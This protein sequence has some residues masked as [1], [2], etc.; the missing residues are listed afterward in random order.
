MTQI[1]VYSFS[2]FNRYMLNVG[3]LA[4]TV[5]GIRNRELNMTFKVPDFVQ[6]TQ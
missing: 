4:N 5:I 3:S 2:L 1:C 6:I